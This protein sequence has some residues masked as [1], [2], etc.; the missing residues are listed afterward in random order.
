MYEQTKKKPYAQRS[1]LEDLYHNMNDFSQTD[2]DTYWADI[3]THPLDQFMLKIAFAARV[4]PMFYR[5][6][7][8][9]EEDFKRILS[10]LAPIL[11]GEDGLDVDI[12][13]ADLLN[14]PPPI[15]P[16]VFNRDVLEQP[17]E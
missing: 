2:L 4:C 9:R 5:C 8:S 6:D 3:D 16:R 13:E 15:P 11:L 7:I 10:V 12:F 17:E 14:P 1:T